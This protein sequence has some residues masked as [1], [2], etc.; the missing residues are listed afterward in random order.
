MTKNGGLTN[1]HFVRGW[2]EDRT[3][4]SQR[5]TSI[6]RV[7]S[8]F[9][10]ESVLEDCTGL[11]LSKSPT[12]LRGRMTLKGLNSSWIL[13]LCIVCLKHAIFGAMTLAPSPNSSHCNNVFMGLLK[14][15]TKACS[16][17]CGHTLGGCVHHS[18][19]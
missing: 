12:P 18:G 9:N 19:R 4:V 7:L 6:S 17:S 14:A 16:S 3:T 10:H 8:F 2:S 1:I 11:P 15:D 5:I 13:N